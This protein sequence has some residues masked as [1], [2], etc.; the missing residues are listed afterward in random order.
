MIHAFYSEYP[1]LPPCLPSLSIR[2]QADRTR[3]T[4]LMMQ[5]LL[6]HLY[7]GIEHRRSHHT[8][9][10]E[11][12]YDICPLTK[13]FSCSSPAYQISDPETSAAGLSA[14][15]LVNASSPASLSNTAI[16]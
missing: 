2:V 5:S 1:P 6:Q 9:V 13:F 15:G 11:L 12:K 8:I 14:D 16:P 4:Q 10:T 3:E 7:Q